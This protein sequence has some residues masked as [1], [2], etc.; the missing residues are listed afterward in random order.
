MY[1]ALTVVS[2]SCKCSVS[3]KKFASDLCTAAAGQISVYE[4]LYTIV[5]SSFIGEYLV[6]L[7]SVFSQ[8]VPYTPVTQALHSDM[9]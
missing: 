6:A 8:H 1:A 7:H 5:V 2:W 9:V 3:E 4:R